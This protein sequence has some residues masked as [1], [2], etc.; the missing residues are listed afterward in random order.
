ME[1]THD[2]RG[3]ITHVVDAPSAG[4]TLRQAYT[5]KERNQ[6]RRVDF[7]GGSFM[8]VAYDASGRPLRIDLDGNDI[9]IHYD[10]NGEFSSLQ[11]ATEHWVRRDEHD[12]AAMF[13]TPTAQ[14]R[15]LLNGDA[16]VATQPSYGLIVFDAVS[17]NATI[18][19]VEYASIPGLGEAL[20]TWHMIFDWFGEP[21]ARNFEKPS[22]AVFQPPEYASTNCSLACPF[23]STCGQ[24]CTTYFGTGE[25]TCNCYGYLAFGPN[26]PPPDDVST[27]L[28][29]EGKEEATSM[30]RKPLEDALLSL[31]YGPLEEG[32]RVDCNEPETTVGHSSAVDFTNICIII[33]TN[34]DTVYTGHTHPL[35]HKTED[36]NKEFCCHDTC[37][38]LVDPGHV[39]QVNTETGECNDE[40][41]KQAHKTGTRMIIR[42]PQGTIK[43]CY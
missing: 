30:A 41:R 32:M 29:G 24:S 16:A 36:L 26:T 33:E 8:N 27:W 10:V 37:F 13:T 12:V 22:N 4:L 23:A 40:D 18:E 43:S 34:E 31:P 6:V 9:F 7:P 15:M 42:T 39:N 35:F 1:L 5:R 38:R 21:A 11:N 3:N 14:V 20:A 19:Q 28:C 17:F 2:I 25:F